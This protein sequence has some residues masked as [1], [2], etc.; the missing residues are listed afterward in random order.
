MSVIRRS[1]LKI[2]GSAAIAF[3]V[4]VEHFKPIP[5]EAVEGPEP[6]REVV[7]ETLSPVFEGL[8]EWNDKR[9]MNG[10]VVH[11]PADPDLTFHMS[12]MVS[13]KV[14]RVSGRMDWKSRWLHEMAQRKKSGELERV[15][16]LARVGDPH[17][18]LA[19]E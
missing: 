3:V 4:G 1:F 5:V 14:R 7:T 17:G 15:E 2:F 18:S 8:R 19:G 10:G 16:R 9:L 12:G 6:N 13:G 11:E